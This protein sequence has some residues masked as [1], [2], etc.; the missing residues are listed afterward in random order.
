MGFYSSTINTVPS[1][2]QKV[3]GSPHPAVEL[4]MIKILWC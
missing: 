4:R 2:F 1:A 3:V